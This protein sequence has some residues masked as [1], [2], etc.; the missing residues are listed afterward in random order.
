MKVTFLYLGIS[1]KQTA[2]RSVLVLKIMYY[3][4]FRNNFVPDEGY[5]Y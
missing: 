3:R 1:K 5:K 4:Y 2:L